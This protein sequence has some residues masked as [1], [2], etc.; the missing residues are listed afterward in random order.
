MLTA[1]GDASLL[2]R[3][4]INYHLVFEGRT[5]MRRYNLSLIMHFIIVK[6]ANSYLYIHTNSAERKCC[7]MISAYVHSSHQEAK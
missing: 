3:L 5:K 6:I 1:T 4:F 2:V 7:I